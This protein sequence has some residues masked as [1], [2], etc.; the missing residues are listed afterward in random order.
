MDAH[1]DWLTWT[2]Q[3]QRK[4]ETI[5]DVY[6]LARRALRSLSD[7]HESFAFDG[8]GFDRTSRISNFDLCLARDD[9]G[10]RIG[11]A[12][13]TGY[14]LFD[15]TGRACDRIREPELSR[16]ITME[17]AE[18]LTRFDYAVDI[19]TGTLPSEFVNA[20]LHQ[21][22]R[23]VSFIRSDT[24][25]TA[26]V[27]SRKSDRFCRVYRYSPPH[28]RSHLL[29]I[30]YVFRRG[31]AR[32]AAA[33]YCEQENDALFL[34][35]LG[36]TYGWG[37]ADYKPDEKTDERVATPSYSQ[38]DEDTIAWLYKQVMPAMRRLIGTGVLDL[39]HFLER[40]YEE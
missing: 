2:M 14:L 7:E 13:P 6:H 8:Q 16:R 10:F 34:S 37:H 5:K 3:P 15:A 35:K 40:V 29:R 31:M 1:V 38:S 33:Q 4:P 19:H 18:L 28:P 30:E 24:G 27:G 11:G 26:Y 23:S 17:V 36:N 32:A 12:G 39:A 20:R 22:F 25:E 21:A 9:N